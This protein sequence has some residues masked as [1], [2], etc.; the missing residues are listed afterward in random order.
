MDGFHV[1][2]AAS[3]DPKAQARLRGIDYLPATAWLAAHA[4]HLARMDGRTADL[5]LDLRAADVRMDP[6]HFAELVGQ[7]VDNAF[8]FS[9][10]G[11][12]VRLHLGLLPD[13]LCELS[14]S[15]QGRGMQPDHIA[16]VE[17]FRQFD[18]DV[19]S[20]RA[21]AWGWPWP[22]VLPPSM[23]APWPSRASPA[24]AP[25]FASACPRP[26]RAPR[27]P[28]SRTWPCGA[29]SPGPWAASSSTTPNRWANKR[30]SSR[31]RPDCRPPAQTPRTSR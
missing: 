6:A 20:G 30:N 12:A 10:P 27:A 29:T 5:Q 15:D 16:Q 14:V 28:A 25:R 19:R 9:H 26:G 18:T 3:H 21:P 17:A 11:S 2:T 1:L 24:R 31:L 22:G 13:D 7:L 23:A 8:K 4:G